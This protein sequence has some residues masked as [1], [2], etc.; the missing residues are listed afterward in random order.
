MKDAVLKF[1][2]SKIA[3]IWEKP[4]YHKCVHN[5]KKCC[6]VGRRLNRIW[7]RADI[8]CHEFSNYETVFIFKSNN[9]SSIIFKL[10]YAGSKK[11]SILKGTT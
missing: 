6:L 7:N 3:C 10:Y 4:L 1:D 5:A 2:Q 9:E 11:K 8:F